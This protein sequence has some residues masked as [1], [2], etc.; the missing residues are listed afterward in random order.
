MTQCC[1]PFFEPCQKARGSWFA[2]LDI[3]TVLLNR[4]ALACGQ[5]ERRSAAPCWTSFPKHSGMTKTL[6]LIDFHK[7]GSE[8]SQL[9]HR[10]NKVRSLS[11]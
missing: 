1:A 9:E 2:I 4:H 5:R 11:G 10:S 8:G 6:N 3:L 7:L